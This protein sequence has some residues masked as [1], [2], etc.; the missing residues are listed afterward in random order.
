MNY[1]ITLLRF[2]VI[3][4]LLFLTYIVYYWF[5]N[6]LHFFNWFRKIVWSNKTRKAN[7]SK[8][9]SITITKEKNNLNYFKKD[10]LSDFDKQKISEYLKKSKIHI[11]KWEIDL[12]KNA[13][14]EWLSIDKFNKELN[15][16][17]A[18]IYILEKEFLKAEYIYKDLL[19]ILEWDFDILKKL[20]Y[21]LAMQ[22]KY[23]LSLEI[24]KKAYE[25]KK[26]DL[27]IVNMMAHLYYFKWYY[28]ECI[29]FLR[30]FLKNKPRDT[31]NLILLWES[32][33]QLWKN[34]DALI[35]FKKVLEI[36]PYN[37]DVKKEITILEWESN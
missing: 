35:S 5:Y 26:D 13:I 32:Y 8:R 17:L 25:I 37:E 21:I 24:Y 3:L 16:E 15:I 33:K 2:E 12:A 14:I 18:W 34:V 19:L 7:L 11:S 22:E 36:Q 30:I 31:E 20:W 10:K 28:L 4:F 27:E 1:S 23:D 29:E 6:W 9:P